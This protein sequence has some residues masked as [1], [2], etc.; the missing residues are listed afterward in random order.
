[1]EKANDH[2]YF[3]NKDCQYFPCHTKADPENFNCLFCYCPI[4]T[5][6]KA[7]GGNFRYMASGVKDC[8]QCLLPH[9]PGGYE[10]IMKNFG[11]ILEQMLA[12]Q[13]A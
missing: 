1:M 8:S 7:C 3:C 2:S 5:L 10:Y 9:S 13:E 4:Y 6:G 12:D 11:R